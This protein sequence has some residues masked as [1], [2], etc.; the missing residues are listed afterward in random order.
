MIIF[1]IHALFIDFNF[2]DWYH[3]HSLIDIRLVLWVSVALLVRTFVLRDV[4]AMLW[5]IIGD[6][7]RP[8]RDV[9]KDY[10]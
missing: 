4:S 7:C 9:F 10:W 5:V 2:K 6:W 1:L 3:Y 8:L